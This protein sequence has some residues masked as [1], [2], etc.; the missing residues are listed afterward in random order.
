MFKESEQNLWNTYELLRESVTYQVPHTPK[1]LMSDFYML[2]YLDTIPF[3]S[4]T[5]DGNVNALRFEDDYKHDVNYAQSVLYPFLKEHLLNALFFAMCSEMMYAF[6][7]NLRK[8]FLQKN[9]TF[10][11]SYHKYLKHYSSTFGS[12]DPRMPKNPA[13]EKDNESFQQ[14]YAAAVKAM[15][16]AKLDG[17]QTVTVFKEAFLQPGWHGSYGGKPWANIAEAWL[18]LYNTPDNKF[19][20]LAVL[21]DHIYDLQHNTDTVFNKLQSY[22]DKGYKWLAEML[23]FKANL[24]DIHQLL[25]YCSSLMQKL[26]RPVLHIAGVK[27]K[28]KKDFDVTTSESDESRVIGWFGAEADMAVD[29]AIDA[30]ENDNDT[31]DIDR[32]V[33]FAKE[34]PDVTLKNPLI[35]MGID[36]ISDM[37]TD[38]EM[39]DHESAAM[40]LGVNP[41]VK[42]SKVWN[43][44]IKGF[45]HVHRKDIIES[46]AQ[47]ILE[48]KDKLFANVQIKG[49]LQNTKLFGDTKSTKIFSDK[50]VSKLLDGIERY[51]SITIEQTNE[52]PGE[53]EKAE[54]RIKDFITN[55][56]K[57]DINHLYVQWVLDIFC[58]MLADESIKDEVLGQDGNKYN[59][60]PFQWRKHIL[61]IGPEVT[62]A[63]AVGLKPYIA[64]FI[65]LHDNSIPH[66]PAFGTVG[67]IESNPEQTAQDIL[68]HQ[69]CQAVADQ[70]SNI[71]EYY[72]NAPG[73]QPQKNAILKALK[74]DYDDLAILAIDAVTTM[75][76]NSDTMVMHYFGQEPNFGSFIKGMIGPD[77]DMGEWQVLFQ[78]MSQY[79]PHAFKNAAK[80]GISKLLPQLK[81]TKPY[82]VKTKGIS[83]DDALTEL[84]GGTRQVISV[85]AGEIIKDFITAVHTNKFNQ[86]Q[87][88]YVEAVKDASVGDIDGLMK[89]TIKDAAGL[90]HNA[91]EVVN[92]MFDANVFHFL[93]SDMN[94][95]EPEYTQEQ[96][97]EFFAQMKLYNYSA[98]RNELEG[99]LSHYNNALKAAVKKLQSG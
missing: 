27:K 87:I 55:Y 67:K 73:A 29:T 62:D 38:G 80:A 26:A 76:E 8:E 66:N 2:A 33:A 95:P 77:H 37:L 68:I 7:A 70:A 53:D 43:L 57:V 93:V 14:S 54:A 60:N 49:M 36:M 35:R 89:L 51:S 3:D 19:R 25:P 75:L 99:V 16:D 71:A 94:K 30:F 59:F 22:Y 63:V 5:K 50:V 28:E 69:A 90:L 18:D 40:A 58:D 92:S 85:C 97:Y 86:D 48:K 41:K 47:S 13:H 12:K 98:M 17:P 39:G 72:M 44:A 82:T 42:D 96:W 1:S 74:D 31:E 81:K 56:P 21:I 20:Q 10:M 84:L 4:L 32:I 23:D 34:Y 83:E 78:H 6:N 24:K 52:D 46:M 11:Q 61:E 64:S 15:K 45:L 79:M 88:H 91:P 9:M 65:Q